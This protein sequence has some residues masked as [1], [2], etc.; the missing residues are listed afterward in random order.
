MHTK[1]DMAAAISRP[2][3]AGRNPK[4]RIAF[5]VGSSAP[6]QASEG[7]NELVDQAHHFSVGN[8]LRAPQ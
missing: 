1:D 2:G 3:Q 7:S 4:S 8:T 5:H 6:T